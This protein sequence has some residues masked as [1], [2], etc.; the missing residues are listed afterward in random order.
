M[1]EIDDDG[2][3][4]PDAARDSWLESL[5]DDADINKDG[6]LDESESLKLLT[7]CLR[8]RMGVFSRLGQP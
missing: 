1:A 2:I 5:F 6:F 8:F 4:L 7:V 3:F